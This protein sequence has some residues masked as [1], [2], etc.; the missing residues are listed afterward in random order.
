LVVRQ[1][2]GFDAILVED[3]QTSEIERLE[4]AELR[5]AS[6]EAADSSTTNLNDI[7]DGDWAEARRRRDLIAPLLDGTRCPRSIVVERARAGDCATT[8]LYRWA[9]LYRASGL[10][11]SLLPEKSN[12]G[13]GKSR[14]NPAVEQILTQTIEEHYLSRQQRT[15]R[16]TAQEVARRCREASLHVPYGPAAH[17]GPADARTL[18]APFTSQRGHR[19]LCA[20]T[21]YL[22]RGAASALSRERTQPRRCAIV[23]WNTVYLQRA[24][25]ALADG[26]Q[27]VDEALLRHL[28]PLGWEHINL[29]GDYVWRQNKRAETGT[30]QPLRRASDP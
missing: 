28:S 18:A 8:T 2:L 23:L 21:R 24:V 30:F 7:S 25:Q 11:S 17:S 27:A 29:T 10:L 3:P 4:I 1:A 15:V 13:R 19:S 9:R 20:A 22:R 14:L 16:S 5:P 6:A 12:G 26:G